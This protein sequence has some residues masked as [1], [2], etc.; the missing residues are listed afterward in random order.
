S[1]YGRT[2]DLL[3]SLTQNFNGGPSED[4]QIAGGNESGSNVSQGTG[5]NLRGLGAGSTLVLV[6]GRRLAPRAGDGRVARVSSIPLFAIERVEVLPDGASAI[7]GADAVGGVVNFIMRK[8][9]QGAESQVRLGSVTS[10]S[11]RELLVSQSLGTTWNSGSG[12]LALEFGKRD[13][14]A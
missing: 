6:N 13:A 7:Y 14:L 11:A 5:G 10:G 12:L 9:Y 4:T 2:E 3:R 8:N 1:G